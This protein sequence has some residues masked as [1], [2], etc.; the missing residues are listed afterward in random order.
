VLGQGISV[1]SARLLAQRLVQR[2]GDRIA[3]APERLTHLFPS[4]ETLASA[5]LNGMGLTG[6]KI[7]G[8]RSLARAVRDGIVKLAGQADEVVKALG[9]LPGVGHW[10]AQ[11]VAMRALG[12]PDA[13]PCGDRVIRRVLSGAGA[14]LS[15]EAIKDRAEGWR[16][17]RGYATLHLWQEASD[18]KRR[19][20][21]DKS[22]TAKQKSGRSR[23]I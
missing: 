19:S 13:F 10:A 17:W 2:F 1:S 22:L 3:D 18:T 21:Q 5:N 14:A 11:Y 9:A 7:A 16:P 20:A 8:L 23:R 4:A 15:N 12:E 6:A